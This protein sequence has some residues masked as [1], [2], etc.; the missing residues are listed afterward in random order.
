MHLQAKEEEEEEE[1]EED[2]EEGKKKKDMQGKAK[3]TK[4][5]GHM[6][7]GSRTKRLNPRYLI[8]GT[9]VDSGVE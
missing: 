9:A 2:E 5:G 8:R 7:G 3:R 1:E 4:T 6:E